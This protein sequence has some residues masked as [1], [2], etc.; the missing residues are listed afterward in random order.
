MAAQSSRVLAMTAES[1]SSICMDFTYS[2]PSNCAIAESRKSLMHKIYFLLR[3]LHMTKR[4]R[5][6]SASWAVSCAAAFYLGISFSGSTDEDL[7]QQSEQE[8][9][10]RVS[11]RAESANA[12]NP[13]ERKNSARPSSNSRNIGSDVIAEVVDLAKL[14]DPIVRAQGMLALV[15]NLEPGEYNKGSHGRIWHLACRLGQSRPRL[16][17]RLRQRKH[18]HFFRSRN[19][20][21]ELG[22]DATRG[23]HRLG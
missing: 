9:T 8:K 11:S 18:Q 1:S 10:S 7:A 6:L 21:R 13:G 16:R 22:A 5:L 17:S 14:T 12:S 2:R 15:E 23:R 19:H 20:S 3:S 4:F